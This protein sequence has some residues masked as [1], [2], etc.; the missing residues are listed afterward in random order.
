MSEL[1]AEN[2]SGS[3]SLFSGKSD[4]ASNPMPGKIAKQRIGSLSS[5][6]GL[7]PSIA[8]SIGTFVVPFIM[9]KISAVQPSGGFDLSSLT[10]MIF[11]EGAS[12]LGD[13]LKSGLGG[14]LGKLF[15]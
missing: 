6:V 11:G 5:K 12:S 14:S 9:N 4:L 15:G 1:T 3:M 7:S 2:I 10:D 13:T 8:L